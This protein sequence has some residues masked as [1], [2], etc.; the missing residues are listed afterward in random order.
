MTMKLNWLLMLAFLCGCSHVKNDAK[1]DDQLPDA[2][3]SFDGVWAEDTTANALFTIKGDTVVNFEHGDRMFFKVVGDT[4]VIDYG[5]FI[6]KHL[7]LKHTQ[8]S[9]VLQNEDKS[10]TRLYKR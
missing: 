2:L 5:D 8:D 6:G 4:I 1:S 9:L 3:V 7:I 10:I